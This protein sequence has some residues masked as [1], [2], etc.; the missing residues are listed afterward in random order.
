MHCKLKCNVFLN[1]FFAFKGSKLLL[2]FSII[3]AVS[4][5]HEK[6]C[7]LHM[8]KF[9]K[10]RHR[11]CFTV[12]TPF[13]TT[14]T[15]LWFQMRKQRHRDILT[16]IAFSTPENCGICSMKFSKSTSKEAQTAEEWLDFDYATEQQRSLCWREKVVCDQCPYTS[17]RYNLYDEIETGKPGRKSATANVGLNIG[18]KSNPYWTERCEKA[19]S[20]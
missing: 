13:F 10:Q 4:P 20:K 18:L 9:R 2:L 5:R 8:H 15:C 16:A 1:V 11:S 3:W 6:T 7:F 17:Q 14:Y 19:M 12:T